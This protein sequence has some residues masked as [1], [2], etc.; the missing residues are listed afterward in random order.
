MNW[1]EK[2]VDIYKPSLTCSISRA[3]KTKP[4]NSFQLLAEF[5]QLAYQILDI[6]PTQCLWKNLFSF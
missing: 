4:Q 6:V 5:F 2:V 1:Q 3:R